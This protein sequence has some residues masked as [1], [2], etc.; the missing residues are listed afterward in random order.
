MLGVT[1]AS[2]M[3]ASVG[4]FVFVGSVWAQ[5]TGD[6][7][8]ANDPQQNVFVGNEVEVGDPP[9]NITSFAT[10]LLGPDSASSYQLRA[11]IKKPGPV[12]QQVWNDDLEMTEINM[13]GTPGQAVLTADVLTLV[14][15]MKLAGTDQ[16]DIYVSQR[17]TTG[18]T[19][20]L[21]VPIAAVQ[22]DQDEVEPWIDATCSTVYFRRRAPGQLSD[23]GTIFVAHKLATAQ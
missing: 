9:D 13:A 22:S 16:T 23:P 14:Y 10:V 12:G 20:E 2:S 8:I 4:R 6:A 11:R 18:H 17:E 15:A 7:V 21:G 1:E 3:V 19:F 5:N